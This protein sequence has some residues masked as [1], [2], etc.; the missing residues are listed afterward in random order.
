M[1][2]FVYDINSS[3]NGRPLQGNGTGSLELGYEKKDTFEKD[4]FHKDSSKE[5]KST[6]VTIELQKSMPRIETQTPVMAAPEHVM[7]EPAEVSSFDDMEDPFAEE[8]PDIPELHDPLEGYNRAM[9]KFNDKLYEHVMEPVARGYRKVVHE[10][11]RIGIRNVFNNALSPVKFFSSLVQGDVQKSAQVLSR[12]VINTT[13]G[14]GGFFDIA[15]KHYEVD[16][17]NEDF[18]Q[19]LGVHGVPTGPYLVLPF[20]GPS[21]SR[22]V[23]GRVVDSFLSPTIFAAPGV[24]VG[25]GINAVDQVNTVSFQIDDKESLDVSALDK[26]ESTRDF[27]HQYRFGLLNK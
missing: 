22:N 26:Y 19:A 15:G 27:Y 3:E 5:V 21:H 13:V 16:D 9:Y 11:I 23:V 24:L 17:V 6:E 8:Q 18:D 1:N 10:N 2:E 20:L 4:S 14:L 7:D 12:L 25:M